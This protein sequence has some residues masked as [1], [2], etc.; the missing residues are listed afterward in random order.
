[1][2]V[3]GI[4]IVFVMKDPLRK[5]KSNRFSIYNRLIKNRCTTTGATAK[6]GAGFCFMGMILVVGGSRNFL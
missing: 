6:R 4:K 3:V 1:M 2:K 5:N